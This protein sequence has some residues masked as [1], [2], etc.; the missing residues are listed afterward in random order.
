ML[1][2]QEA[3]R[4]WEL[5]IV[6]Q[7]H[8]KNVPRSRI[9]YIQGGEKRQGK[10]RDVRRS[11]KAPNL[12]VPSQCVDPPSDLSLARGSCKSLI[13]SHCFTHHF[14]TCLAKTP[15]KGL[16]FLQNTQTSSSIPLVHQH[17]Y[18]RSHQPESE[19][20]RVFHSDAIHAKSIL[21]PKN[22]R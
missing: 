13:N 2:T 11:T 18:H 10:R 5:S 12:F 15:D 17:I 20:D 14:P 19:R 21:C 3:P 1:L 8:L 9:L 16:F 22:M 7:I 4:K 6:S